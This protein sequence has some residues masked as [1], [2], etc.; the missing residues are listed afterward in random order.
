MR[1]LSLTFVQARVRWLEFP[2]DGRPTLFLHGLGCTAASD[3]AHVAARLRDRRS[4][5]LDHLGFGF[6]DRPADF[7]YR[8][9]S[10]ANVAAAVL[11]HLGLAEVDVVAHSMGGAIGILLA[12]QRPELVRRLVLSEPNLDVGGGQFS[13]LLA[14]RDPAGIDRIIKLTSTPA[15]T[16]RA[17]LADPL[18]LVR[19][20]DG[21]VT[22]T[23]PPP[24]ELL[25]K[26]PCPVRFLVGERSMPDADAERVAALGVPVS[27]V[28]D[29]G[30]DMSVENPDDFAEA[31]AAALV[32]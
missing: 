16:A 26:L 4:I 14:G 13:T 3:F 2:G 32:S 10:H 28:P 22:S 25:A 7:D 20:A 9:E 1:E 8:I 12:A 24:I 29:A 15:F 19:S 21:L 30:H 27:I 6:S 18:A 5:L 17:R 31:V 11:D 23:D